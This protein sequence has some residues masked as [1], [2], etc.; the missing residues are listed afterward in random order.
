MSVLS[1]ERT[2]SAVSLRQSRRSSIA[3]SRTK[4]NLKLACWNLNRAPG[5]WCN[6]DHPRETSLVWKDGH[7][8]V[9]IGNGVVV[10]S[11]SVE[12]GVVRTFLKDWP[13]TNWGE[14]HLVDYAVAPAEDWQQRAIAAEAKTAALT[15]RVEQEIPTLQ[16]Q[17][18]DLQ[19][20]RMAFKTAMQRL[21]V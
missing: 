17:V 14:C 7:I 19:A 12:W 6:Y 21:L 3:R 11:R 8:G 4:K 5:K 16:K 10:E 18:Q 2:P 20:D 9:Y 13:W 1:L 15:A